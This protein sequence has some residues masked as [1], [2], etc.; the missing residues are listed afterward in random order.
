MVLEMMQIIAMVHDVT[1]F[2]SAVCQ[3]ALI[4]F[5]SFGLI[6]QETG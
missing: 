2:R 5:A 3:C 6:P 4:I 1:H